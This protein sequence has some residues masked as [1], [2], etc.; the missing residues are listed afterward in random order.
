MCGT[1]AIGVVAGLLMAGGAANAGPGDAQAII[2]A[3]GKDAT[4]AT[5]AIERLGKSGLRNRLGLAAG[6]PKVVDSAT[7]KGLNPGFQIAV[8]GFCPAK[9][10]QAALARDLLALEFLGTYLR[11]VTDV[12]VGTCPTIIAD[13]CQARS[14]KHLE[15]A[16][17]KYHASAPSL[18]WRFGR[19]DMSGRWPKEDRFESLY[20]DLLQSGACL[21]GT[22]YLGEVES[23]DWEFF[24]EW[25]VGKQ[26]Q[27]PGRSWLVLR[28]GGGSHSTLVI[29]GWAC[30]R[31]A[32]LLE[33]EDS[34]DA[35]SLEIKPVAGSE[36]P[37]F[38]ISGDGVDA[39]YVFDECKLVPQGKPA[40]SK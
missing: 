28:N 37:A 39:T 12:D 19:V 34:S 8:A 16:T 20:V 38:R 14:R 30:G 31:I 21:G 33:I 5:A 7:V 23:R 40:G 22:R 11:P 9:G 24:M 2:F 18:S 3:G 29:A 4:A 36:P 10:K 15:S 1:V 17:E 25:Q 35:E 6:F 13:S 32:D 27:L 26:V